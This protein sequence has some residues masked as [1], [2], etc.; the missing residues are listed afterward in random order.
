MKKG[1]DPKN[2]AARHT[3]EFYLDESGMKTGVKTFLTLVLDYM[4]MKR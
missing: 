1:E 4:Y 3:P 2:V